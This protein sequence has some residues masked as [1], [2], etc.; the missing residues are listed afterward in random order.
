MAGIPD[1][2]YL[3]DAVM[4][5]S[6][7][8]LQLMLYDGAIRFA[9][10]GRAAIESKDF[11][12][13]FERLSRAQKIV[14]EMQQ[15]L[16]FD[17]DKELCE[18]MSGLYMYAYRKLVD[19]CCKHTVEE[20]DEALRVLEYERQTWV[21]LMDKVLKLDATQV[22]DLSVQGPAGPTGGALSIEG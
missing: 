20:V 10:Q 3:R 8:Q 12:L 13:A 6:P 18:R 15:G 21:M 14:L 1:Q 11:E 22:V 5:A 2:S 9:R 16:N 19:A 4:T 7:E 17:V